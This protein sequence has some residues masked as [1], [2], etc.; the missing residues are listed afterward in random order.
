MNY[1]GYIEWKRW[2]EKDFGQP[3]P[4]ISFY[5][6]QIFKKVLIKKCK[7]LE[8]GFGNGGGMGYF[9]KKGH[10]IIGVEVNDALV[11]RARDLGYTTYAGF[12]WNI[13]ELKS[14]SFDLIA[15]FSVVEHMSYDDLNALFS[16]VRGHLKDDGRMCLQFPEGASPFG[17]AYQNG[18]FTHAT[19]LTK[20]KIEVL[21][22]KND[23][24]LFSYEDD[25]SSSNRLCSFGLIGK[26][27]LVMLQRYASLLRWIMRILFYPLQ[28]ELRLASTSIAIVTRAKV[29]PFK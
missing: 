28:P 12:V 3:G 29:D 20:N 25:L 22:E 4:G 27:S 17:L 14:E 1:S 26:I 24:R 23:L 19:S 6:D 9:R 13:P 8:I 15:A 11:K 16:W 18:D 7:V 21:C 10:E 2:K 5:F